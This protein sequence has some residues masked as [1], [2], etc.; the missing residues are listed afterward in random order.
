MMNRKTIYLIVAALLT[1]MASNAPAV[2]ACCPQLVLQMNQGMQSGLVRDGT[3]L[4]RGSL[5]SYDTHTGFE[6]ASEQAV[7][8]LQPGHYVIAGNQN[9]SH[10]L[11]VH[12][13]PQQLTVTPVPDSTQI[14]LN[15]AEGRVVFD[16]LADGDQTVPADS[17]R[18]NVTAL[19]YNTP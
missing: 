3:K 5:A 15:T 13:V 11:R 12:L 10:Q 17:Y 7:S 1:G 14:R 9:P 2:G 4:G 8:T 19:T 16:V 18:L 6:L